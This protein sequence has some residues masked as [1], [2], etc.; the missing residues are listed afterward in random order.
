M[1][2]IW[3][4][5]YRLQKMLDVEI[6]AAEAMAKQGKLPMADVVKIRKRAKINVVEIAEIEKVVNSFD[7]VKQSYAVSAGREVRV[8]AIPEKIDD[9]GAL[10][11]AQPDEIGMGHVE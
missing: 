9:F 2:K 4:D 3:T 6:F 1:A 8:F 10:R 11:A 7:G 5:E